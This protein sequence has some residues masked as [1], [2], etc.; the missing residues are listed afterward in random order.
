MIKAV[1]SNGQY[2]EYGVV[3]LPFPI[4]RE[5]Y[6]NVIEFLEPLEIGD[7]IARD[8]RIK[9]I[10]GD[11]PVL[12]QL[13]QTKTNLDEL[14]YLAKRLDS[15]DNY[16]KAQFQG[17]AS[18]LGLHGVDELINLTFCC[19]EATI[20]T[21]FTNL[22]KVGRRHILTL[23]G[24]SLEKM[25]GE[26]FMKIALSLIESEVG[27]ITPFGVTYENGM[28]L[29]PIYDGRHFP[30]YHYEDC[31][32]EIEM[33]PNAEPEDSPH[34]CY[35]FLPQPQTQIERAMLRTGID[36]YSDMRLR[37][38]ESSLPTEIDNVLNMEHETLSSLNEMCEEVSKLTPADRDKLG[39][40]VAL[41]KPECLLQVKNLASQLKMFD[42]IPG[43]KNTEDYGR[44]MI[45]DSGHFEYDE[46]LD[47]YYN[48]E[49]YGRQ[50]M[51]QKYGEF[52]ERGYVSYNGALSLDELMMESPDGQTN[53]QM[54]GMQ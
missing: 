47:E 51:E 49:K 22:D 19:Q 14:D 25:Q 24:A 45:R 26:D 13:E 54:G 16:E 35:L 15:F 21:D 53:F 46:N 9:E 33:T 37:F 4:P 5:E 3:T 32:L 23:G 7:P 10:S 18:K 28:E 17:M 27:Y 36:G 31:M 39:A 42:F 38:M 30:E 50:R 12:K 20:I 41:A 44:Y 11:F 40:V 1:L 34:A 48:Y 8:C 6:D 52:N 43:A 29:W 2:P